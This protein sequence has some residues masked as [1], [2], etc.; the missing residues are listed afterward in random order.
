MRVGGG[1]EEREGDGEEEQ[2][3]EYVMPLR[4]KEAEGQ[5]TSLGQGWG[6]V[7]DDIIFTPAVCG[8]GH[9]VRVGDCVSVRCVECRHRQASWRAVTMMPVSPYPHTL[10]SSPQSPSLPLRKH[11]HTP[12]KETAQS[13]SR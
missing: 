3:V 13:A 12:S 9:Q 7:D 5:V 4:E 11:T 1:E 10:P 2:E 8:R 6:T